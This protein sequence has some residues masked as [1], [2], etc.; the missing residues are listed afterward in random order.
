[1]RTKFF[2]TIFVVGIVICF[3]AWLF[4][5]RVLSFPGMEV[6]SSISYFLIMFCFLFLAIEV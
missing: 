6:V 1:M 2:I 5:F 3:F 4:V